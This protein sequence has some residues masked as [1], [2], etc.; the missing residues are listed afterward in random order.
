MAER[1]PIISGAKVKYT[2][3]FDAQLL[4]RKMQEWVKRAKF[5][6]PKEVRY[7]E[8]VKPFGKIIDL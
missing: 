7:V 3:A 2:G 5:P 6:L 1:D 4:Y 8:R